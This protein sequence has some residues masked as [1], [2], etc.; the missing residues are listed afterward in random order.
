L[1]NENFT[2]QNF[3][4]ITTYTKKSLKVNLEE[5]Q[6]KEEYLNLFLKWYGKYT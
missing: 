6:V 1:K 3:E 4:I 5:K 2:W